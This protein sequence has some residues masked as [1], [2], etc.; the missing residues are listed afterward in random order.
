VDITKELP[1]VISF[2]SGYGGIER[3]LDLAGVEHRV[4]AFLEIEAFAIANLVNKMEK[5]LIPPAPIYT[6]LK[7]FPAE[8]FRDRVDIVTG[9]YPCQPFS[10]AGSRKGEDDP[11]HLWPFIRRHLQSIRPLQCFFENVEGHISLGLPSV[12]SDLEEDGYST[13]WGIFSAREVGAPH[14][15]KRVFIMGNAQ[16]DGSSDCEKPRDIDKTI[17][18]CTQGQDQAVKSERASRPGGDA[19]L[20]RGVADSDSVRCDGRRVS[21]GIGEREVEIEAE[22]CSG[23]SG[24]NVADT[25]NPRQHPGCGSIQEPEVRNYIGG[26]GEELA[27]TESLRVQGL[28]SSREQEPRSPK[29]EILPVS[30][31]ERRIDASWPTEPSVGRVVD[32]CP[33]RVDRIRLLGNAVVPKTAAKAWITLSNRYKNEQGQ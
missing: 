1:T 3:G 15:R 13:T 24:D 19:D 9:G 26:S 14:Q 16:H 18:N 11:R 17:S 31:G 29:K 30:G 7:T 12:I 25:D 2:C 6:D 32:G 23:E 20:S 4:I 10:K 8:I 27:D 5:G 22:G 28:W 21:H 33:D